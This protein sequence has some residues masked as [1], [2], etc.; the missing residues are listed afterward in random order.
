MPCGWISH[1]AT[2]LMEFTSTISDSL[3]LAT[4]IRLAPWSGFARGSAVYFQKVA[5]RDL[6]RRTNQI[7]MHLWMGRPCCGMNFAVSI[8]PGL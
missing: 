5:G 4:I 3:R 1:D 7:C 2:T 6:I 8:S